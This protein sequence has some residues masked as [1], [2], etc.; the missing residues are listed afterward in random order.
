[1]SHPRFF[2]L[3]A[4]AVAAAALLFA[5]GAADAGGKGGGGGGHSG[6]GAHGGAVHG[7]AVHGGGVSH[8]GAVY[9]GGGYY[10]RGYGGYGSGLYLG[11][12]LGGYGYGG[13]GGYGGSGGYY[14]PDY[15]YPPP[16]AAP[17]GYMT[18]PASPSVYTA[19]NGP[20]GNVNPAVLDPV[21]HIMIKVPAE[22]EVWFG[23]GKT[24]QTGAQR[25]FVSPPLT[26]GQDYSYEI[27]ARWTEGGKE[28]T[29]TRTIDVSAGAWKSID[30][31]K[32]VPEQLEPPKPKQ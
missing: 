20:S 12:G 2:S 17:S 29:Q 24:Q 9:H 23:Q 8:G 32:P 19:P 13:Y 6:G 21:A 5:A 22:A 4:P 1:M 3:A 30:F 10:N 16:G 27:K 18:P 31:T 11:L 26:P 14:A 15:Y 28:V 25:E 7:G